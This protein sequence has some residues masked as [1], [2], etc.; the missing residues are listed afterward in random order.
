MHLIGRLR[1]A[2]K[3]AVSKLLTIPKPFCFVGPDS[4]LALCREI[5]NTGVKRV[6]LITDGPLFNLGVVDAIVQTLRD[7]GLTVEIFDEIEPEPGYDMINAG[8]EQLRKA[9]AQAVLAAGGG[10]SID[11]AKTMVACYANNCHPSKLV[12]MFKVRK[13]GVPFYAIATTAG[14]GSE[15]TMVAI[16]S[17]KAALLKRSIIDPKLIPLMVAFDPN[18]MTGLPPAITAATGMDALTH[19]VEAYIATTATAETDQLAKTATANIL[20]NL[21]KAYSNGKDL[22]V[23][24]RMAIA[25]CTAGLAFTRAGVG[26]VHAIAHQLG[27]LYHVP[28]G[29]ANA[30]VMPCVLDLSK[31]NCAHRLADLARCAGVGSE[32]AGDLELATQFIA[33][34]RKMNRDMGIPDKI[35]DLRREDYDKIVRR[36]FKEAHGTYGVPKYFSRAECEGILHQLL[37]AS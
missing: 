10:S 36:A 16:V 8:V 24:E 15:V 6:A 9:Q 1:I 25:A 19:A 26:Y 29:L 37:P 18:L 22:A 33:R 7:A 28:H 34:I 14:T 21:P 13:A 2:V 17:D 20:R 3:R 23:R 31:Q 27:A 12:G 4:A 30:I 32:A 5:A 35:K 11:G